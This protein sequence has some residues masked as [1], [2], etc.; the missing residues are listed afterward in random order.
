MSLTLDA[1][2]EFVRVVDHSSTLAALVTHARAANL[3]IVL[4]EES[5]APGVDYGAVDLSLHVA[6]SADVTPP[7]AGVDYAGMTPGQRR[8]FLDWAAQP[9]APAPP[10]FRRLYIANL[11][12]HLLDQPALRHRATGRLVHFGLTP[13]WREDPFRQQA[14]LLALWL[15]Q[16]GDLLAGWLRTGQPIPGLVG[17]ALGHLA[18]LQA[19]LEAE[20][21]SVVLERWGI[22]PVA[23]EPDLLKLR[24]ASLTAALGQD[25][26]AYALGRLDPDA[27]SPRPWR[28][29]HRGLRLALP[30]PDLR[31]VLEGPLRD[32]LS[33]PLEAADMSEVD[34][35]LDDDDS[36][37]TAQSNWNLI[38]EFGHS[39]SEFFEPTLKLCR[40]L[41][42]FS[43]I[44]DEDRRVIHR[45]AF[46]K[47]EM[48]RFWRIWENAQSWAS[49]R[50]YLNGEELENWKIWPYSQ[51][52]R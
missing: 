30:Q 41:P 39:R 45:V 8:T 31:P 10:A 34:E 22:T 28:T 40:R 37:D 46:R 3:P 51:Y 52:L 35:G 50:V 48:R 17:I 11:E 42:G 26:L 7:P 12:A 19:P 25:P 49:T 15:E 43:Q 9:A 21:L 36:G 24:L 18:L 2:P 6:S 32:M 23:P 14:M 4:P 27:L 29:A 5:A 47:S 1:V 13:N 20:V 16:R 38:L 33:V 44:L